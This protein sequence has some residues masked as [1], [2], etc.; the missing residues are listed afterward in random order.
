MKNRTLFDT[1]K[2]LSDLTGFDNGYSVITVNKIESHIKNILIV[3]YD[4]TNFLKTHFEQ[5]GH[6]ALQEYIERNPTYQKGFKF[7]NN[8][9]DEIYRKIHR[10]E[11]DIQNG[12][13]R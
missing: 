5:A 12:T 13:K 6:I 7:T 1:A 10:G 8:D 4:E 3:R 11:Y 9:M 2:D